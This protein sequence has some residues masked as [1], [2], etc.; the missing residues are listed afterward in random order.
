M[1]RGKRTRR[2]PHRSGLPSSNPAGSNGS[3]PNVYQVRPVTR[4]RFALKLGAHSDRE[5]RRMTRIDRLLLFVA[6]MTIAGTASAQQA[7]GPQTA[8]PPEPPKLGASNS[9]ELGLIVATG[10]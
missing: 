6:G 5:I 1:P 10:N 9:S 7:Q 4:R 8:Q 2:G 3:A